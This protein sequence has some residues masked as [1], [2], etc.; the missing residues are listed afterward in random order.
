[1]T[2]QQAYDELA[3]QLPPDASVW[4][5]RY[6]FVSRDPR[7]HSHGRTTW[8]VRITHEPSGYIRRHHVKG[9][10]ARRAIDEA[11]RRWH[12][13]QRKVKADGLPRWATLRDAGGDATDYRVVLACGRL[14]VRDYG[15]KVTRE[16]MS[17]TDR[18]DR[19]VTVAA[20]VPVEHR[21]RV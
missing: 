4:V 9:G 5:E 12:R 11:L 2:E 3:A 20:A 1:V 13:Y 7:G 14:F 21:R 19:T 6:G 18:V 17:Y 16:V 15:R 10:T 8:K